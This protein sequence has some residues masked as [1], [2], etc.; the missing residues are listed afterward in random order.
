MVRYP[1]KG[2]LLGNF[3]VSVLLMWLHKVS[4]LF[5]ILKNPLNRSKSFFNTM[6]IVISHSV[7]IPMISNASNC[8]RNA[9]S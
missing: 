6:I 8:V 7:V 1:C 4:S 3:S 9:F 5:V 2:S